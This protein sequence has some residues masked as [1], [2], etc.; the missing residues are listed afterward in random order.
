[1]MGGIMSLTYIRK[2][3]HMTFAN[4]TKASEYERAKPNA[5]ALN[6]QG[7]QARSVA[8]LMISQS[9]GKFEMAA[10]DDDNMRYTLRE[11]GTG[12]LTTIYFDKKKNA[13]SA[14]PGGFS[15]IP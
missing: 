4:S 6:A 12:T 3:D 11:K 13:P 8:E 1:M 14:I 15:A 9:E 7:E 5:R 10:E 2:T